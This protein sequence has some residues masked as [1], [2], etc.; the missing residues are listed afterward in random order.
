[1][2]K[3]QFLYSNMRGWSLQQSNLAE[4]FV[5][6]HNGRLSLMVAG[7][8]ISEPGFGLGQEVM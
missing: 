2:A 1:M 6:Q 5:G 4:V 3:G 7:I 8:I